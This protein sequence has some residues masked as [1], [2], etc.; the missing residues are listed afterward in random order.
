M[1]YCIGNE[2][3]EDP[4][5]SGD[6]RKVTILSRTSTPPP[7]ATVVQNLGD[8]VVFGVGSVMIY[9]DGGEVSFYQDDRQWHL[10][11]G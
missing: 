9:P 2:N 6:E 1:Y 11:G 7:D 3:V 8:H 10:W 5:A 4:N